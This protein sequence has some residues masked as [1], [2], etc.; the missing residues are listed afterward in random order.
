MTPH[1]PLAPLLHVSA[2]SH[3][4]CYPQHIPLD[5]KPLSPLTTARHSASYTATTTHYLETKPLSP[6]HADSYLQR[7]PPT[8]SIQSHSALTTARHSVTPRAHCYRLDKS[9]S[10][11]TTAGHSVT[12]HAHCYPQLRYKASL[13]TAFYCEQI[14][15]SSS[16]ASTPPLQPAR[17]R[18]THTTSSTCP[19]GDCVLLIPPPPEGHCVSICFLPHDVSAP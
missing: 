9:H 1:S 13:T 8:V 18:E 5:T 3:A 12:P 17:Y 16:S 7:I 11:L 19:V 15:S 4:P 10:A 2:A 14:T 6:Q